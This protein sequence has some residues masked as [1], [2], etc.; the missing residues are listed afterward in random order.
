MR[1]MKR[2]K[3]LQGISGVISILLSAILFFVLLNCFMVVVQTSSRAIVVAMY[4]AI[5]ALAIGELSFIILIPSYYARALDGRKTIGRFRRVTYIQVILLLLS[6]LLRFLALRSAFLRRGLP[7]S[8]VFRLQDYLPAI[9]GIAIGTLSLLVL[10]LSF[11]A[12][13]RS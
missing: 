10:D 9:C 7:T 2:E 6:E 12:R 13:S 8:Q 1:Q 11:S 5:I 3:I 4:F